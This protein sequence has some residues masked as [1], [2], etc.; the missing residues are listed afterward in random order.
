LRR[1]ETIAKLVVSD[2]QYLACNSL[3]HNLIKTVPVDT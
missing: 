1:T 3:K 2:K